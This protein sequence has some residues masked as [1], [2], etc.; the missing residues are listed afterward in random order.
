MVG[1]VIVSI[2]I[3]E[4]NVIQAKRLKHMIEEIC[5]RQQIHY[6]FIKVTSREQ[7]IIEQIPTTTYI[8]IYFL[9]IE[10]KSEE[11]KGFE[12]AR[13]IREYD[14]EGIIVFI[15]THAEFAPISYEYMVS[16]LTFIDKALPYEQ[17]YK[18]IEQ[19]L[20][21]YESRN[22]TG[23][24]A[25][26]L[27]IETEQATIKVPFSEVQYV[28]TAAPHRL[29]LVTTKRHI[30]FYGTLKELEQ[31]EE[32]LLRCHQSYVVNIDAITSYDT[33]SRFLTLQNEEQIPV[34]RRLHRTVKNK[35]RKHD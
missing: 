10:I 8:P 5:Q 1:G 6:D 29:I 7:N 35:L 31:A 32:R 11:Q 26:D 4:D 20:H 22:R 3:Y 21:H 18:V 33:A 23:A 9:D 30:N 16:A 25:K 2:F 17:R 12:V 28:M 13:R 24:S 34:S 15:T 19:C 27:L 14:A